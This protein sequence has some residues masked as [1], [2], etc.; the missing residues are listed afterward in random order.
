M[1]LEGLEKAL[2]LDHKP[3][4]HWEP[5]SRCRPWGGVRGTSDPRTQKPRGRGCCT[6][7]A[8]K[9]SRGF[10][11]TPASRTMLSRFG[12]LAAKRPSEVQCLLTVIMAAVTE[13]PA[14]LHAPSHGVF[15][16]ASERGLCPAF[17]QGCASSLARHGARTAVTMLWAL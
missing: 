11:C 8:N 13:C 1:T 5:M 9:P 3:Q 12:C 17:L 16:V 10:Q 7:Y 14:P 4:H 6:V 2:L 15:T